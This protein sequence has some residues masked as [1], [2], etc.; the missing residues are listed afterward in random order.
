MRAIATPRVAAG[1]LFRDGDG[2]V[3]L[4]KPTYKPGRDIPGGFVSPDESPLVEPA[5]PA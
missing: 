4:V 1:A 3:L 5:Q 2:R